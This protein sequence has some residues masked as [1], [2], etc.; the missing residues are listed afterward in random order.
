MI[1]PRA[2]RP[3]IQSSNPGRKKRSA[4]SRA[5]L[6]W[7]WCPISLLFNENG[8]HVGGGSDRRMVTSILRNST[9][10]LSTSDAIP[11]IPQ[12]L[13]DC[14]HRNTFTITILISWRVDFR[15]IPQDCVPLARKQITA[16]AFRP[17]S[18]KVKASTETG[19]GADEVHR[20][21][22]FAF[23]AMTKYT[24]IV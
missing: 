21:S 22:W 18:N 2:G 1:I 6:H 17:L 16:T 8:R 12:H 15:S 5:R 19:N 20:P 9:W 4:F 3:T 23:Q 11:P 10:W 13:P 14:R 7:P 24:D